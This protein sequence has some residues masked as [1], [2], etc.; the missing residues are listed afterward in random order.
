M[1]NRTVISVEID[2]LCYCGKIVSCFYNEYKDRL[3]GQCICGREIEGTIE[4][5]I[6][7]VKK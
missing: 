4:A 3:H 6:E 5:V 7:D 2:I 1:I